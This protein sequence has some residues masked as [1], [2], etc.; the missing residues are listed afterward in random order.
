MFFVPF[1]FG[2]RFPAPSFFTAAVTIP[3]HPYFELKT[4]ES[5][6]ESDYQKR[7]LEALGNNSYSRNELASAMGYKGISAKL[8]SAIDNMLQHGELEN[9]IVGARVKIKIKE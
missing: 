6:K 8:S 9:V 4:S 1:C 7:I 2:R 5:K 3:V